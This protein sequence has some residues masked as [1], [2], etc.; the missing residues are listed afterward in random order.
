MDE[1]QLTR[2]DVAAVINLLQKTEQ[3]MNR[4]GTRHLMLAASAIFLGATAAATATT[5]CYPRAEMVSYISRDFEA[6]KMANGIVR[7]FSVMELWV[8]EDD[9]DWVVV[10][11]DLDEN[12]CIVAYGE[13]F[14]AAPVD[15]SGTQ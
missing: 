8:S 10:T 11:T 13:R 7:P 5:V 14:T 3:R 12:S 2:T 6:T 4:T 1:L 9:G 15:G